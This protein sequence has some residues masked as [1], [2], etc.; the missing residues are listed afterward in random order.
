MFNNA[1]ALSSKRVAICERHI[2]MCTSSKRQAISFGKTR[3]KIFTKKKKKQMTQLK[4]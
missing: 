4:F 3:T 2:Q 1:L